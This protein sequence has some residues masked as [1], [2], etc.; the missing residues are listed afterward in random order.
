MPGLWNG[1]L[2][3]RWDKRYDAVLWFSAVCFFLYFLCLYN[4]VINWRE[5]FIPGLQTLSN[6]TAPPGYSVNFFSSSP[7][8]THRHS[9][10]YVYECTLDALF[11]CTF[12]LLLHGAP[13]TGPRLRRDKIPGV[14][15]QRG[16]VA[17]GTEIGRNAE[18]PIYCVW[19]SP[20]T[21][22]MMKESKE[23]LM[24]TLARRVN[25]CIVIANNVMLWRCRMRHTRAMRTVRITI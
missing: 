12:V 18:R 25:D 19:L 1:L 21:R 10:L 14:K 3:C 24:T 20:V 17:I 13:A 15:A 8:A 6:T 9:C 22:A 5:I 23:F 4:T 7:G 16:D 2:L 11:V